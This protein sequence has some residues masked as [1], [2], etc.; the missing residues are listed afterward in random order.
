[1]QIPNYLSLND[2]ESS[3]RAATM[4]FVHLGGTF[5][6]TRVEIEDV[7]G[8]SLTTGRTTQQQRHLT[9]GNGLLG[10]I[11]VNDERV[12]AIVTEVFTYLNNKICPSSK[13]FIIKTIQKYPWRSR[14]REPRTAE[15]QHRKRWQPRR[16]CISWHPSQSNA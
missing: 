8:V 3:E 15:G 2:W 7:T 16:L 4:D 13:F 10:Q 5:E 1:M 14:N 9:V 11:V 12:L 6:Q